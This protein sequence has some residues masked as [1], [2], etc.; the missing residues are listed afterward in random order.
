MRGFAGRC[1]GSF[2]GLGV[3]STCRPRRGFLIGMAASSTAGSLV[4]HVHHVQLEK[5]LGCLAASF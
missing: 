2:P 3:G 4:R 5:F 1:P